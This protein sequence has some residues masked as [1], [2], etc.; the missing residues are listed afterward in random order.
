M[1]AFIVRPFGTKEDIDFD[2]VEAELIKPA[3]V[4]LGIP[5]GTTGEIL[6]AGDIREDMFNELLMADL[7]VADLSIHNA[8]VFYELGIRHA[9]RTRRTFLLRC[10]TDNYPFDITTSRYL[11]YDSEHPAGTLESLIQSLRATL[12]SERQDSPVFQLLPELKEQESEHFLAVHAQFSEDVEL[13][14]RKKRDGDLSLYGEEVKRLPWEIVALRLTGENLFKL[15]SFDSARSIWERVLELKPGD[16]QALDRLSTIYQRLGMLEE[17]D[18]AL[19]KLLNDESLPTSARVEALALKGRNDKARWLNGWRAAPAEG[20][21]SLALE[22]QLLRDA[23]DAYD[24]AFTRDLNHYYSGVNALGLLVVLLELADA[25]PEEWLFNFDDEEEATYELGQLRKRHIV[26][27]TLVK[28]S[29]QAAEISVTEPDIWLDI[30]KA[31]L[32]CLI[33]ENPRRVAVLYKNALLKSDAFVMD[34]ARKQLLIYDQLGIRATCV[35]AALDVLPAIDDHTKVIHTI[36]FTGH[37]ID[38]P[39]RKSPRFPADQE[40]VAQQ[41]IQ[42]A[43]E[44]EKKRIE[45]LYGDN[46]EVIFRGISGGA[47]GGDILFHEACHKL[48][49]ASQMYLV[50]PREQFIQTSVQF[51]GTDWVERFNTIYN[52]LEPADRPVLGPGE[53]LP[54][55][56]NK[57]P[58]YS[59]WVRNN[60]W[61]LHNAL[62]NGGDQVT[63]VALWNR[64][65]GDGI[66]GTQDMVNR[67][68]AAGAKTVI[69]DT[70]VVFDI[71]AASS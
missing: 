59:I 23:F 10:R 5:G 27:S 29:V 13:A 68:S 45:T 28:S 65:G 39:D 64:E 49:I 24:E 48:G 21:R 20:Q 50:F 8:N 16:Q 66:G 70:G 34:S 25:M 60:L 53:A 71:R 37:M 18:L 15:R 63:L 46:T 31:D 7:V 51:A 58:D 14:F 43:L 38:Q 36:L 44:E 41:A 3:L 4:A 40:E 26:L 33:S 30:T 12:E 1:K 55:W 17:S 57:K 19:T 69:I 2:R 62:V 52:R 56:L 11:E 61:M 22:S 42:K 67:A 54:A 9:L 47:C 35:K 6:E 32:Q